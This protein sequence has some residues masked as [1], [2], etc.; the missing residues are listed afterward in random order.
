MKYELIELEE[1]SQNRVR[2]YS[3]LPQNSDKALFDLFL[4]E[5]TPNH[6]DEV[7]DIY[8]RLESISEETGLREHFYKSGEG[9]WGDEVCALYDKPNSHLRL[10][11]IKVNSC[12]II[13]GGGGHK[14][15]EIRAYQEDE[16]LNA[17][18]GL[19]KEISKAVF[20]RITN[21]EITIDQRNNSLIGNLIFNEKE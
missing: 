6:K 1:F 20:D 11:F 5:N 9:N 2:I 15:K 16:K 13:L 12:I 4:D 14:R 18:A 19:M 7:D 17:E 3:V 21:K 10:Y 8:L